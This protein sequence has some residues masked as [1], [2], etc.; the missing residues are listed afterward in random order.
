MC[1]WGGRIWL[2]AS[3]L[4]VGDTLL[5]ATCGR[6]FE[7]TAEQMYRALIEILGK[8]PPETVHYY[9]GQ[10]VH[11]RACAR[12]RVCVHAYVKSF[13]LSFRSLQQVYCGHE[14]LQGSLKYA[15]HVEPSNTAIQEKIQWAQV[16][17]LP[18]L[19]TF[20]VCFMHFHFK[21]K[22]RLCSI[23]FLIKLI[24]SLLCTYTLSGEEGQGGTN[25]PLYY[26]RSV[27]NQ[28]IHESERGGSEKI[29]RDKWPSAGHAVSQ[30]WK[31]QI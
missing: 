11:V 27:S 29:R 24:S 17:D 4:F 16:S 28:P 7:G 3:I 31:G 5:T 30:R 14:Y 18:S 2:C 21:D 23:P 22:H 20:I 19:S 8:L 13:L 25:C 10:C 6:F 9:I 12:T 26:C 15:E 1:G